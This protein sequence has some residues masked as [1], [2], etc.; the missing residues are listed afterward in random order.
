M[1]FNVPKEYKEF[2][3]SEFLTPKGKLSISSAVMRIETYVRVHGLLCDD[4][5]TFKLDETLKTVL[6]TDVE[7]ATYNKIQ[8]F[9]AALA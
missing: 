1:L 8:V 5:Q 4:G 2:W 3:G 6:N 9:L 7:R